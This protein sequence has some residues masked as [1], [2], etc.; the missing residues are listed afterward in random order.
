MAAQTGPGDPTLRPVRR[1]GRLIEATDAES[2]A[3]AARD[4]PWNL[5]QF[6]VTTQPGVTHCSVSCP[7]A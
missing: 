2:V 4:L 6:R 5:S 3:L 7:T 1:V